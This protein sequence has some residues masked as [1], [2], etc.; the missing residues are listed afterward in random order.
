MGLLSPD[1]RVNSPNLIQPAERSPSARDFWEGVRSVIVIPIIYR[2]AREEREGF[3]K[4]FLADLAFL[5]VQMCLV[6]QHLIPYLRRVIP[7]Q[8]CVV[9]LTVKKLH[10]PFGVHDCYRDAR[11]FK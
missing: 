8:A 5:A 9:I 2:Q 11:F 1:L 10:D 6:K 7:M 4:S 3:L